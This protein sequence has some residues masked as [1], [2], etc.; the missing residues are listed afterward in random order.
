MKE[1][2]SPSPLFVQSIL[3]GLAYWQQRTQHLDAA[4]IQRLDQEKQNLYQALRMGLKLPQAQPPAAEIILGLSPFIEKKA[5]WQEWIQLLQEAIAAAVDP[6]LKLRLR[7]RMGFFHRL[8]GDLEAAIA[9]HRQIIETTQNQD[10][11]PEYGYACFNLGIAS[12]FSHHYDQAQ[13]YG[14]IALEEFRKAP[15]NSRGGPAPA[16][17]LLGMVALSTGDYA[18]ASAH[19]NEALALWETAQDQDYIVRAL[20]NLAL[21]AEAAAAYE[22]ALAYYDRAAVILDAAGS[23]LDMANVSLNRGTTYSRMEQ[24]SEAEAAYL[25]VD[26]DFLRQAGHLF[27]LAMLSTNLGD[28]TMRQGRL[29]TAAA[30]LSEAVV[31][32]R[33]LGDSLMLANALGTLGETYLKQ[34]QPQ[35]AHPHLDEALALLQ[36]H[37]D[38]QWAKK[39]STEFRQRRL[40]AG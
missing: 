8:N 23:Q 35:L 26:V 1:P 12:Y 18:A 9:I 19:F 10:A 16:I 3:G 39:L 38:N 30:H 34:D 33:Q 4:T 14:Q 24:W 22:Q 15:E 20:L 37:P 32:W 27:Q 40:E 6:Q 5:Y 2:P 21:A 29:E 28:V 25:D 36:Q 7:N 17:N 31:L 13:H 11:H